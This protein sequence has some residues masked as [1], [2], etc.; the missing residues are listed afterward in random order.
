MMKAYAIIWGNNQAVVLTTQD[1]NK[2]I[3][4]FPE[5]HQAAKVV[6]DNP[7]QNYR[8]IEVEILKI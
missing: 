3:A 7:D 6:S 1:G 5:Y 4:V 8:I 2:P